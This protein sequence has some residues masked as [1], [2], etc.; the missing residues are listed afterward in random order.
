MQQISNLLF[1]QYAARKLLGK[2]KEQK[3]WDSF[4]QNT[5]ANHITA[6]Y[7]S[8]FPDDPLS[9]NFL[10]FTSRLYQVPLVS[11]YHHSIICFR[12][13]HTANTLSSLPLTLTKFQNVRKLLLGDLYDT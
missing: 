2:S 8:G 3:A 9:S 7:I 1:Q 5:V 10:T 6:N 11:K 13:D 12:T 4:K